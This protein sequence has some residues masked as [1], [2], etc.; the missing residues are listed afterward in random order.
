MNKRIATIA[1][2]ALLVL[3]VFAFVLPSV[4]AGGFAVSTSAIGSVAIAAIIAAT[5]LGLSTRKR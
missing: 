1:S 2:I 4:R 5:V 3:A